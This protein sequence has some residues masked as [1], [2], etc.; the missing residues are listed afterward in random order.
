[1]KEMLKARIMKQ[2]SIESVTNELQFLKMIGQT[3][4]KSKKFIANVHYA[5]QSAENLYIVI[6]LLEG[7]DLRFHMLKE[8]AFQ[9]EV[10]KF[11][12]ACIAVGLHACH[13]KGIIHRDLKPENLVFDKRGYLNL[14]DFGIAF[15]PHPN[16][17]ENQNMTSGTPGYMAPEVMLG[18]SHTF[19]VDYFAL[20]CIGYE[21]IT[22]KRPYRGKNSEEIKYKMMK[23]AVVMELKEPWED[24]PPEAIDFINRCIEKNKR[25][26]LGSLKEVKEHPWFDGFDWDALLNQ[27]MEPI[28]V[29]DTNI[30]KNFDKKRVE[31]FKFGDEEDLKEYQDDL[32]STVFQKDYF[33]EY[34]H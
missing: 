13:Q 22:S 1:M 18:H 5:F 12:M 26:R 27:T 15:Q 17:P 32:R 11:F 20:G 24:Y 9:P 19:N 8:R 23:D 16:A 14:T 34:Y 33:G 30:E 25:T 29:P 10:T 4:S 31:E 21:C 2:N 6:D 28:Y 7:G 3:E